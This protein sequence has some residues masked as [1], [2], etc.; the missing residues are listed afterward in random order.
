V[1]KEFRALGEVFGSP[2]LRRLELAWLATSI[3]VWG[4]ALALAIYAYNKGGASAVGLMALSRT[5]PAAPAAPV[6]T[7]I[8]D[9]RPRRLVLLTTNALR[10]ALLGAT[11]AAVAADASLGAVYALSVAFAIA[12]PAYK[13]S[14][15][16]L[17]PLLARTP[18]ELSS[19]NVAATMLLNLGFLLGSLGAGAL[20]TATSTGAVLAML[21]AAL[22]ASLV[23]LARV[24]RDQRPSPTR[25]PARCTRRSRAS[26]RSQATPSCACS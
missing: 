6:L 3:G 19:A 14:Q 1:A 17:F 21:A 2:D 22:A 10:A 12:G 7:L 18:S 15:A 5:L 20:L 16:A 13:P 23:A 8:A 24:S 26:P 9:R 11:A 25:M 4:S